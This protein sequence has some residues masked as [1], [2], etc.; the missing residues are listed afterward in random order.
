MSLK[1]SIKRLPLPLLKEEVLAQAYDN[2]PIGGLEKKRNKVMLG[3]IIWQALRRCELVSLEVKDL[4]LAKGQLTIR[5]TKRTNQRVLNLHPRQLL[6]LQ[7]YLLR[8][9]PALLVLKDQKIEQFFIN[10]KSGNQIS[11]IVGSLNRQLPKL[12]LESN[13]LV[14]F[15]NL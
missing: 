13:T 9:R 14:I 1:G 2:F 8:V 7:N 10:A 4:D 12:E 6:D 15:D 5:A 3:L 11:K